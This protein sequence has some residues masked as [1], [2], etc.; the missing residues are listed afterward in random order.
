[1]GTSGSCGGENLRMLVRISAD[2]KVK[3]LR[4]KVACDNH[5]RSSN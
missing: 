4:L 5:P 3:E 1:M 2:Q